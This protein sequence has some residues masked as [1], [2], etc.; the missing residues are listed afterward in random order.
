MGKFIRLLVLL[1]I[2]IGIGVGVAKLNEMKQQFLA[3]SEEEQRAFQG[4]AGQER[5]DQSQFAPGRQHCQEIYQP[6]TAVSGFDPG[7]QYRLDE[8]RR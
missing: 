1:A 4:K 5:A 7:G 6:G 8:G 3:M 2:A